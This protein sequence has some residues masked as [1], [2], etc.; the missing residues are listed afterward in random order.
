MSHT[1]TTVVTKQVSGG[2]TVVTTGNRE[3]HSGVCGCT[4]DCKSCALGFFCPLCLACIVSRRIGELGCA[5]CVAGI[6]PLRLK[7]RLMLG[8]KGTICND[9]CVST[10]CGPCVLC[11]LSRELDA[12]G[13]PK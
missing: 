4:E 10:I 12:A 7:T 2:Q 11:Q 3:W 6:H 1:T 13:W 8:I 5:P 9:C